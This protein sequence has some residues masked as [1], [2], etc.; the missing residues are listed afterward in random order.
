MKNHQKSIKKT[1]LGNDFY[2]KTNK[3]NNNGIL[4]GGTL[5]CAPIIVLPNEFVL[6]LHVRIKTKKYERKRRIPSKNLRFHMILRF[7]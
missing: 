5:F 3:K 2:I 7:Y 6:Q 4:R 1:G